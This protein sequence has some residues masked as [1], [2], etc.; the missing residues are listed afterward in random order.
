M[1]VK[2]LTFPSWS[3]TL[4]SRVLMSWAEGGMNASN[5]F[6]LGPHQL[7]LGEGD[8]DELQSLA[9]NLIPSQKKLEL[10]RMDDLH[11]KLHSGI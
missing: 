5:D 2:K 10:G 9:S 4:S 7:R 8:H 1:D 11:S 3:T 6:V